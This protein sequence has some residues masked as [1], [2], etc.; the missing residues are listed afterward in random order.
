MRRAGAGAGGGGGCADV[1][2]VTGQVL[3]K[4]EARANSV[5]DIT[6]CP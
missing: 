2:Q 3:G 5:I 4:G 6:D 1:V